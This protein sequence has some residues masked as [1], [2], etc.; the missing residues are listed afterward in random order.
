MSRF[1]A[2]NA[3]L[4]LR[5]IDA[6]STSSGNS[7]LNFTN[8]S[9]RDVMGNGMFDEYDLFNLSLIQVATDLTSATFGTTDNDR[10]FYINISGLDFRNQTYNA[11]YISFNTYANIGAIKLTQGASTI[12]N[13]Y[14]NNAITFRKKDMCNLTISLNR[15]DDLAISRNGQNV[16]NLFL[17]FNIVGIPK[18]K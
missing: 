1:T 2:Q 15:I 5:T 18:S 16:P 11:K 14:A 12:Q 6:T 9:F 10:I 13:F 8:I 4:T 3:S 7:V 17:L